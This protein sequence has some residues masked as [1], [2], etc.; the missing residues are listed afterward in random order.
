V[1]FVDVDMDVSGVVPIRERPGLGPWLAPDKIGQIDG[2]LADEMDR[3]SRDMLDYLQFARDMAALEKIIIDVSDGTDTGTERGRQALEDRILAA[4]RERERIAGRRRRA[5]G[6]LSN[7]GRWGGGAPGFGYSPRCECHNERRC[8]EPEHTTGWTRVQGENADTAKWMIQQRIAGKGFSAI[9]DE[10]NRQGVLSPRGDKWNATTVRKILTSPLLLGH[11]V[12]MKGEKGVKGAP[13]YKKGNVVTT[14]RGKD[15]QPVKFTDEPL[16]DQ[17]TWD[18]LQEAIRVGSK[19]RGL[20]QSRHMLYRV[21]FCR[22]CSP[23]PCDPQTAAVLMYGSRRHTGVG[24]DGHNANHRAYYACKSCGLSIRLD[25]IEW[26]IEEVMLREVGE[27]VL[28]E[29]RVVHGDDH[30]AAIAALV[31]EAEKRKEMLA[32]DPDDE[33]MAKS[34]AAKEAQITE[35]R[36]LPHEPDHF[37]WKEAQS[38]ITVAEHWASLDTAGR[39]KF[40]RDWE[41]TCLADREGAETRLGWLE[42]YSDTFRLSNTDS[43]LCPT[44]LPALIAHSQEWQRVPGAVLPARVASLQPN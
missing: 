16:I 3:L 32:D 7:A 12:E 35:L 33:N 19:A 9:A 25:K 26:M 2:F 37:E 30:A 8:P 41:V 17:A 28:L 44:A 4:Q 22:Y 5:A 31:R 1:I 23:K 15:G 18:Q 10:L 14:K 40:L 36:K 38:G 21:L 6:E 24:S 11:V 29:K 43:R 27:N 13:G 20:P 34:L 39:A 42:I